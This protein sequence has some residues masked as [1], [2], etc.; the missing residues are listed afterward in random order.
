MLSRGREVLRPSDMVVYLEERG[1][2]W[3]V[4]L[5]DGSGRWKLGNWTEAR[6]CDG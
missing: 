1:S 2:E 5:I 3:I 4:V 6:S